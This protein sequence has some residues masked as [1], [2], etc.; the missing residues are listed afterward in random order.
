MGQRGKKRGRRQENS[1]KR[2]LDTS[3]VILSPIATRHLLLPHR[4]SFPL[5]PHHSHRVRVVL[6]KNNLQ[7]AIV[8]FGPLTQPPLLHNLGWILQLRVGA[9][10]VATEQSEFPAGVGAFEDGG[11]RAGEGCEAGGVSEGG[12]EFRGCGAEFFI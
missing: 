6:I 5:H 8:S 7:R 1:P 12:V 9:G 3:Y 10:Y 4:Y 2:P 11:G